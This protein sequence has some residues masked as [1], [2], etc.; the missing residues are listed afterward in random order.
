MLSD[1]DNDEHKDKDDNN[2]N[3]NPKKN[4][5]FFLSQFLNINPIFLGLLMI[6]EVLLSKK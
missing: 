5:I 4:A 3:N 6:T 1:Y 2:Y